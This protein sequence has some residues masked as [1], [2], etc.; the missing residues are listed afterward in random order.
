LRPAFPT[1][2]RLAERSSPEMQ[3]E[4]PT[5]TDSA[6]PIPHRHKPG[7]PCPRSA[8]EAGVGKETG[9]RWLREAYVAH[10]RGGKSIAETEAGRGLGGG[11]P[12]G[13]G[14]GGGA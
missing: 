10:R 9:Y 12:I 4:W 6:N 2:F 13:W 14:A 5:S 7:S 1:A 3:L 8:R 11:N